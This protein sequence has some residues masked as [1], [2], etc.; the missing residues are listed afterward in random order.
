[1]KVNTKFFGELEVEEKDIITFEEGIPGFSDLNKYLMFHDDN[2]E[3]FEYLQ[4]VENGNVCFIIISPFLIMPDY[5]I[6]LSNDI[7]KKLGVEEEK[8][9]VLYSIV[10]IPEDMTKMTANLKAPLII[11]AKNRKA[12]QEVIDEEGYSI[13]HRIIKEADAS[14]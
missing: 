8:D 1:M 7:V 4:A 2:N 9:V 13:K 10:T 3:Y 12:I 14:C 5:S 6:D 11:N